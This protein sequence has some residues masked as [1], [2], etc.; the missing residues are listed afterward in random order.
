MFILVAIGLVS[1]GLLVVRQQRLQAVYEMTGALQ[2]SV[3]VERTL[4][5]LR[6][7]IGAATRP[8][9]VRALA[10]GLGPLVPIPSDPLFAD[11]ASAQE[12]PLAGVDAPGDPAL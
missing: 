4:W 2:R 9:S 12:S 11:P 7:H 5:E 3:D 10:E 1:C 6:A 8:D